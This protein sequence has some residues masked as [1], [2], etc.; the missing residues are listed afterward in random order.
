[1]PE[2]EDGVAEW[3]EGEEKGK[4][5]FEFRIHDVRDLRRAA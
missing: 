5:E 1:M 2:W 4:K 3:D